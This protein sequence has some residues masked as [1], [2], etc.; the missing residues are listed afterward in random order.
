MLPIFQSDNKQM[1]LMQTAWARL[2][3]PLLNNPLN[4]GSLLQDVQ[5]S[6]GNNNV[7]HLLGRKLQGWCIVRQRGPGLIYDLQDTNSMPQLTLILNSTT[8]VS[9]DLYVF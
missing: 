7:N 6:T 9:V 3:E 8:S 2:I 1:S 4:K 5:L